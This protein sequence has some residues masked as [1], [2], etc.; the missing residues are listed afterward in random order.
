MQAIDW[1]EVVAAPRHANASL[2][3]GEIPFSP[4]VYAWFKGSECVY[5]GVAT[6]LRRRLSAHRGQ[7]A[8]LSR[9]TLRASV[10]VML[11]GVTRAQAR[12]RPSVMNSAQITAV[13]AWFDE[14]EVAWLET[15]TADDA[16][17]AEH[18]LLG[19]WLPS[20]NLR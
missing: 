9:S 18:H 3:R 20:L 17:D 5:L 1:V 6:N 16:R 15:A 8:D 7:S 14:A 2:R 11:V 4:G 13:N 12:S 19:R 10:A